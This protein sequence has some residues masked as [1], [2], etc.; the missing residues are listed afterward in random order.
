MGRLE[1]G[2]DELVWGNAADD[3]LHTARGRQHCYWQIGTRAHTCRDGRQIELVVWMGCCAECSDVFTC[4]SPN[5]N[6]RYLTRRCLM[7]RRGRQP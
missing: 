4:T 6:P 2:Y 1:W 3:A 7:C 5:A